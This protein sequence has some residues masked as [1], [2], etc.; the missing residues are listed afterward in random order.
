MVKFYLL[1]FFILF[2]IT[3]IFNLKSNLSNLK[4]KKG[5]IKYSII[6][7]FN[8]HIEITNGRKERTEVGSAMCTF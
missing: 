1:F 3:Q 7:I 4:K 2:D 6:I 5:N 8:V